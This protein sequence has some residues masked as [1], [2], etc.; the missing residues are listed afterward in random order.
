MTNTK[1][2]FAKHFVNPPISFIV[3]SDIQWP[4]AAHFRSFNVTSISFECNNDY[5]WP[6]SG[7]PGIG[8]IINISY[9]ACGF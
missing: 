7:S 6:N 5:I 4:S 8:Q 2:Y 9:Y 1:I 3:N